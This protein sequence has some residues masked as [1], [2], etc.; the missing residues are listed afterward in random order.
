M[1]PRRPRR[2][3]AEKDA[4]A[5]RI[6][7]ETSYRLR[8]VGAPRLQKRGITAPNAF[9]VQTHLDRVMKKLG[10]TRRHELILVAASLGLADCPCRKSQSW[11]G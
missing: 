4:V 2:A 3:D 5:Q 7:I 11:S 8:A 10:V 6:A 1:E 9:T